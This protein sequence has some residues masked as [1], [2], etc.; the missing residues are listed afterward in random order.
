MFHNYVSLPEGNSQLMTILMGTMMIKQGMEL[1]FQTPA[2]HG[3]RAF[4]MQGQ[5]QQLPASWSVYFWLVVSTPLKNIGQL[6][7]LFPKYGKIKKVP[8]HQPDLIHLLEQCISVHPDWLL[9]SRRQ[10]QQ[11]QPQA[12]QVSWDTWVPGWLILRGMFHRKTWKSHW[13]LGN[14]LWQF[15]SLQTW[16]WPSRNNG[17]LPMKHG[18]IFPVRYVNV[19]QAGYIIDS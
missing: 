4:H 10:H 16:K 17:W 2:R 13:I 9:P 5:L 15:N 12:A 18:W 3:H 11:H 7:W 19:Y 1:R 14:T 6:G 8:N